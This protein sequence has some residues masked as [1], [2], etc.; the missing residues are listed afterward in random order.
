VE[1]SS[2]HRLLHDLGRDDSLL[3]SV[4]EVSEGSG[5][6]TQNGKIHIRLLVELPERDIHIELGGRIHIQDKIYIRLDCKAHSE[7]TN[8]WLR[9][10]GVVEE[11]DEGRVPG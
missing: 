3:G 7:G 1:R 4:A 5:T 10:R 11:S 6:V 9:L 2:F 8:L